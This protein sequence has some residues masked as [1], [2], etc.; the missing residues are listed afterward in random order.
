MKKLM[1]LGRKL[2]LVSVMMIFLLSVTAIADTCSSSYT[3]VRDESIDIVSGP[4]AVL[5]VIAKDDSFMLG[6][7]RI[8]YKGADKITKTNPEIK[9]KDFKTGNTLTYTYDSVDLSEPSEARFS[10]KLHG[11]TYPFESISYANLDDFTI[12]ELSGRALSVT[13]QKV[14]LTAVEHNDILDRYQVRFSINGEGSDTLGEGESYT[15]NDGFKITVTDILYQAYVGGVHS[16][17]FCFDGEIQAKDGSKIEEPQSTEPVTMEADLSN[18]PQLFVKNGKLN[19][20]LI[21]GRNGPAIDNLALTDIATALESE[22]IDVSHR[23]KLDSEIYTPLDNNLIVVGK[24]GYNTITHLL[25]RSADN[26][27]NPGEGMIK[28]FEHNG[29]VQMLVTGYS[30]E[31]T[32]KAAKVLQNYDNYD[33]T[34]KEVIVTGTMSNPKVR[35]S[36]QPIVVELEEQEEE[37]ET[38]QETEPTPEVETPEEICGECKVNGNCLPYGTRLVRDGKTVYCSIDGTLQEQQGLNA[39]CQNNYECSSNQCSNAKCIDLSGQIEETKGI[40][41]KIFN[42]LSRIFG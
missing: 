11:E 16:A 5:S 7:T 9:F 4:S 37:E 6:S 30:A 13:D 35:K 31:D 40:L 22:G 12:R 36:A 41:E 42:W 19:S 15:S 27:L 3:L 17:T 2:M 34:G 24:S 20:F 14:T 8:Q 38:S 39:D 10:I 25:L 29:Y 32:R 26:S 1:L 21:V 33:L 18:Y 28:L 23:T